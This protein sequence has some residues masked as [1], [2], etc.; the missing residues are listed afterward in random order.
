MSVGPR[1]NPAFVSLR[2]FHEAGGLFEIGCEAGATEAG[3]VG[4]NHEPLI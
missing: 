1:S 3:D 4:D 2:L